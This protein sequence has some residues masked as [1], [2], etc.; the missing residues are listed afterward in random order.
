MPQIRA[1]FP[2]NLKAG[3]D[4][5]VGVSYDEFPLEYPKVFKIKS[6]KKRAFIEQSM[7]FGAPAAPVKIEGQAFDSFQGGDAWTQRYNILTLGY[8]FGLTEESLEDNLY[9]DLAIQLGRSGARG[10]REAEEILCA[11]VINYGFT[12]GTT[13]IGDGKALF[14]T[15][16]PLAGSGGT[17]SNV[18]ATPADL[19]ESSLEDVLTLSRNA[20]DDQG[21]PVMIKP[22]RLVGTTALIY[23]GQ[24]ILK[25]TGRTQTP[26]NDINA[27]NSLGVFNEPMHVMTRITN[28]KTWFVLT[29][30]DYGF[31]FIDRIPLQKRQ[32]QDDNGNHIVTLRRRCVPGVTDWR[33]GFSGGSL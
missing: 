32:F 13:A 29:N 27:I 26:D 6:E 12:A 10:I 11:N 22:V 16:H 8:E 15:D 3:I 5:I 28:P 9:E 21:L 1:Q 31:Q 19:S 30:A 2:N 7:R 20:V 14:A 33:A 24:R 4:A 25:S 17:C 23:T 18:L